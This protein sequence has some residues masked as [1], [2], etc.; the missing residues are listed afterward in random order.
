MESLPGNNREAPHVLPR[1]NSHVVASIRRLVVCAFALLSIPNIPFVNEPVSRHLSSD[2][3]KVIKIGP[4]KD[5]LCR[6][7]LDGDM[8]VWQCLCDSDEDRPDNNS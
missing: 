4:K 1:A 6:K 8:K 5:P 3:V 7:W 2:Q